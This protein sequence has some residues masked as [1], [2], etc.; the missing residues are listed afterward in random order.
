MV[1]A[2][3]ELVADI[4]DLAGSREFPDRLKINSGYIAAVVGALAVV[5]VTDFAPMDNSPDLD[6]S[7]E[8]ELVEFVNESTVDVVVAAVGFVL[9]AV[10]DH[11]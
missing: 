11:D 1:F 4:V 8:L 5:A 3:F 2:A 7:V 10:L 9:V 6:G